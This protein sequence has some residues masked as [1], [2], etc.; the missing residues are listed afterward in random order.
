MLTE[1]RAVLMPW[2]S[3]S[4]RKSCNGGFSDAVWGFKGGVFA[5]L[6]VNVV[7]CRSSDGTRTPGHGQG[8]YSKAA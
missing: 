4:R 5:S 8:T 3:C 1:A 7:D 2:S 6:C